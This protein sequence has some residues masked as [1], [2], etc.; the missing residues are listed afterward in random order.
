MRF[1]DE[2]GL[3][4]LWSKIKTY[5]NGKIPTKV[6]QLAN[7]SGF[8]TTVPEE[9]F[10][11]T[12][13]S[14]TYAEIQSAVNSGK[15]ILL[16]YGGTHRLQL[17]YTSAEQFN[18]AGFVDASNTLFNAVCKSTNEWVLESKEMGGAKITASTVD[19]EDGVSTLAT[20]ELYLVYEE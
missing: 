20:G 14:T 12:Y 11:A 6:S 15:V 3:A 10:I 16:D 5:V 7:D 9:L 8:I 19:L 2:T 1:L 4:H 18:F 17:T 13:G